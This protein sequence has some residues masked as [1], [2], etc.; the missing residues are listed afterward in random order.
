MIDWRIMI[1]IGIAIGA[2]LMAVVA[3]AVSAP[4]LSEDDYPD[5]PRP[6]NSGH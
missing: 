4:D 2:A 6:W 5:H 3:L 1:W